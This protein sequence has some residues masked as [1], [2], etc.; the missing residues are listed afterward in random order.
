MATTSATQP[1]PITKNVSLR[2][3]GQEVTVRDGH[4]HPGGRRAARDRASRSSATTTATTPSGSAACAWSTSAR[5]C[6]PRPAC[7]PARRGWRSPRPVRRSIATA[8]RSPSCCSSDQPDPAKD[9][10]ETTT[11]DNELL[12]LVRQY[13]VE[14]D[15]EQ[16]PQGE[17]RGI[18]D[19]NPVIAVNHDACIL[20][21]R[22]V[23]ACDDIQGNDVIGRSG[24][25]YATRIAFDLNDPMGESSCVTCGE[26]VAACPT[27]ALTNKPL[28]DV[29]IRPRSRA[30]PGR[31]RLPVLRRGL[32]AHLPRR[33]RAPGGRVC[34]GPRAARLQGPA[35]RQGPLRLGLRPLAAAPHHAAD[36]PRGRLP[37]GTA[38]GRRE[39][40]RPRAAQARRPG[41]LRRGHAPLPRGELGGG[42]GPDRQPPGRHP[43]RVRAGRDRRLRVGQVLKRRGLPVPEA[44]PRRALAPTTST[45]ARGCVTP[46]ASPRCSRASARRRSPPPTATS[47][48]PTSR[49]LPAPTP[50]PTTRWPRRSS[51][52]RADAG[53]S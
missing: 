4:H 8:R 42:D 27:G 53:P 34:R 40:R 3:D 28:H 26:C 35:V 50:P 29:P 19:S 33:R 11:A 24:K 18:D 38:V 22:C 52:R 25:G 10:K 51:S 23:R 6:T 31:H 5:G 47:S 32:R 13:G 36:P 48:T 49:S 17:G 2:I 37:Q 16:L 44:D 20:C 43:R 15:E 30:A 41:R 12:V 14:K 1:T 9:P 21:D 7:A 46:R 45:T 39:G